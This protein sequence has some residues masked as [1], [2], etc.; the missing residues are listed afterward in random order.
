VQLVRGSTWVD[1]RYLRCPSIDYHILLAKRDSEP[2]GYAVYRL[3]G[4]DSVAATVTEVLTGPNDH[5]AYMT[6]V[7]E[8][9]RRCIRACADSVRVLSVPGTPTFKR[10]RQC[11]FLPRRAAFS[12]QYVP[13]QPELQKVRNINDWYFEGG[14]FDVV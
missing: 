8:I 1:R 10:L 7:A 14:D 9:E 6:L 12:L 13:L 11:G 4:T 5:G 3:S 2:V